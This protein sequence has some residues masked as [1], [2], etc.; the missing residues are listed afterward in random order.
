MRICILGGTGMLGHKMYQ[1]IR[2]S[3]PDTFVTLHGHLQDQ[4][5]RPIK[6]F[7]P[8][9][10]VEGVDASDLS[11]IERRLIQLKPDVVINCIGIIKQRPDAQSA[12]ANITVNSLMPHRLA[13]LLQSWHA[14]FIHFSTD[15]VF[16]GRRGGYTEEDNSDAEDLYG[17]TK[18]L[19][20]VKAENATTLRT[21]I[22]GRE[23]FHFRSL[24]E[25]FLSQRGQSINGYTQAIYSGVTTNCIAEVVRDYVLPCPERNGLYQVVSRSISKFDLL[26]IIRK[27]FDLPV[28]IVPDDRFFCNRS[29]KGDKFEAMTGFTSPD[30]DTLVAQL[31]TDPTPYSSWRRIE[32][33]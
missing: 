21:S 3:Y 6:L 20:E 18:F 24:L 23:L 4:N 32:T 15:C 12:I 28:E 2:E 1:V 13:L 7:D 22:I 30:W 11:D 17:R 19:G 10:V 33:I 31:A 25:W 27:H 26:H 29:M 9:H 14:R 8:V 5:L 16:S